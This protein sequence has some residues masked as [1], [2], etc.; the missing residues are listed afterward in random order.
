M[1]KLKLHYFG[2]LM[3]RTDSF[4]KT[5]MQRKIEG[6][7]RRGWQGMRW[8]DGIIDSMDMGLGRLQQLVI[9]REAWRAAVHGITK[10]WTWL[11]NWT[12]LNVF[13]VTQ[14]INSRTKIQTFKIFKP[15][16]FYLCHTALPARCR[17]KRKFSSQGWPTVFQQGTLNG[18]WWYLYS[19]TQ[20]TAEEQVWRRT[21]YFEILEDQYFVMLRAGCM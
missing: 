16:P 14:L 15:M 2:H 3:W 11:S 21:W 1:L 8:L 7:R 4:E 9:D 19:E 5:L 10:S 18:N 17:K 6:R 20:D 12:E 13:K